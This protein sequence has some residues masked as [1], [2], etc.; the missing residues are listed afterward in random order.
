M[1][2]L[3]LCV[4]V[5]V[6]VIGPGQ[7]VAQECPGEPVAPSDVAEGDY[8]GFS[9]SIDGDFAIISSVMDDV[10]ET[11]QGSAYIY[12]R[13]QLGTGWTERQKL[14]APDA[15]IQ[16]EFGT[17]VSISGNVAAVS[18]PKR[19]STTEEGAVY[20]FRRDPAQPPSSQW[21]QEGPAL[22]ASDGSPKDFFGGAVP[23]N[24]AVSTNGSFVVVGA[25]GKDIGMAAD[26]GKIDFFKHQ[27]GSTPWLEYDS[28]GAPI[29]Q[30]GAAFGCAVAI[31]GRKVVIGAL[32]TDLTYADQGAAFVYRY[33]TILAAWVPEQQLVASDGS[34][35]AYFGWS[36]SMDGNNI[37]VGA[38]GKAYFFRFDGTSWVQEQ[39]VTST[40]G[41]FGQSVA[42]SGSLGV[43]GSLAYASGP[44]AIG[45]AYVYQ[46]TSGSPPWVDALLLLSSEPDDA[47]E[48]GYTVAIDGDDALIGA[49]GD[50][51][52]QPQ[53]GTIAIYEDLPSCP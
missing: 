33:D 9:I 25:F 7:A 4:C 27:G 34:A 14:T 17:G 5:C 12:E 11:D 19:N 42:I 29:V 46:R 32:G 52:G 13:A 8:F 16:A 31:S 37:L 3:N 6:C 35:A 24:Q 50:D 36:V 26:A 2:R 39:K 10:T 30:T 15:A 49:I 28:I 47:D 51:P 21:L 53:G 45:A 22:T 43:V 44:D 1:K 41:F 20:V 48:F 23:F 40:D 38:P 18:E